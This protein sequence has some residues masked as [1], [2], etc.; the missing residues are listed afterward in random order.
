VESL[1]SGKVQADRWLDR[2]HGDWGGSLAPL[3]EAASL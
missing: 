2:Y 3:Y 1:N